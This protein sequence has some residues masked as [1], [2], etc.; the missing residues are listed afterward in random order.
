LDRNTQWSVVMSDSVMRFYPELTGSWAYKDGVVLK[1]IEAVWRRTANSK[2]VDFIKKYVDAQVDQDG[3][4][5]GV[6]VEDYSIDNINNGKVLLTLYQQTGELKYKKAADRLRLQLK[7]HPRTKEGGFW[8][9]KIYPHQMW[10]DGLYMGAPFYA[11]YIEA[12]GET[13][14]FGDVVQQ[15][16]LI[17]KHLKDSRTGLYYHGWDESKRQEWADPQTGCSPC[18]WSRALGWF[19]MAIVDVLDYL[20]NNYPQRT[21]LILILEKLVNA[22]IKFQD[23]ATHIWYQV[24]DQPDRKGNYLEASAS[25]MVIYT[26]AKAVRQ[27]Y[28]GQQYRGFAQKAFQGLLEELVEVE[29]NGMVILRNTCRTAGLGKAPYANPVF[30]YRDG[31]FNYYVGE[32]IAANDFHGMGSFIM[33]AAEIEAQEKV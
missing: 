12:F 27:G 4:I 32:P 26:I 29:A 5:Q 23:P 2:Y 28:L 13:A 17:D 33:A 24:T 1:G 14:E 30:N 11:Q 10:L 22:V 9:K 20:P 31:S 6:A 21:E 7:G 16:I 25:A 15:F 3:N 18:F 8:H 19:L